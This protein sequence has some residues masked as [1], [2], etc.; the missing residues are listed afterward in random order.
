MKKVILA[1]AVV[2]FAF[3]ACNS[4]ETATET[5][6]ADSTPKVET[7][8]PVAPVVDTTKAPMAVDTTKK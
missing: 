5:P 6:A 8:A 2:S 1:L 3:A 7:P 4:G